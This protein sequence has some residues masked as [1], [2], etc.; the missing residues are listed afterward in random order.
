MNI[1]ITKKEFDELLERIQMLNDIALSALCLKMNIENGF[2]PRLDALNRDL[3][4]F[5]RRFGEVRWPG[6]PPSLWIKRKVSN[7]RPS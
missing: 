3:G 5:Q 2:P 4:M 1:T 7:D 6:K